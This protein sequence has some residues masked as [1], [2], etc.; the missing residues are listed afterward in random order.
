MQAWTASPAI[1]SGNYNTLRVVANGTSLSF[2]INGTLVWNGTDADLSNGVVGVGMYRDAYST[3]NWLDVD[4]ATLTN[5]TS[6]LVAEGISAEQ[7]A[8]NQFALPGGT[9]DLGPE[10]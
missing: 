1:I 2:Y 9:E 8:L 10:R 7:Q 3:G 4:Y 6:T 5:G